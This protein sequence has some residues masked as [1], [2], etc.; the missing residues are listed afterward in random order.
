MRRCVEVILALNAT[1]EGQTTGHY[2]AERCP[3]PS[4]RVTHLAHGV[5][6]GGELDYLDDGT[7][8]RGPQSE[9]RR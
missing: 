2:I 1:V 4:V 7:L 5:P 8:D 9:A 6:M 3:A